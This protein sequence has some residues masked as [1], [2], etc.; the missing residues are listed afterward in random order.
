ME[1]KYKVLLGVLIFIIPG[2]M[3]GSILFLPD[4]VQAVQDVVRHESMHPCQKAT[5]DFFNIMQ[6]NSQLLNDP[7]VSMEEYE[8]FTEEWEKFEKEVTITENQYRCGNLDPE[9]W[10]L[11][12]QEKMQDMLDEGF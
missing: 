10:T 1:R 7:N 3:F 11:E 5:I 2:V 4:Q 12:F 6:K 8:E 9:W